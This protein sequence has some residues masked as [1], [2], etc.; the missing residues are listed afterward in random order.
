V[1]EMLK[2]TIIPLTNHILPPFSAM[3]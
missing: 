1:D 2:H 3:Q